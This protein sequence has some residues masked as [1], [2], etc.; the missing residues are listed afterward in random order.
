MD[1]ESYLGRPSSTKG[2]ISPNSAFCCFC[3]TEIETV[4]HLFFSCTESWKIWASWCCIWGISWVALANAWEFFC[5]WVDLVQDVAKNKIWKMAFFVITWS[6]WLFRNKMVFNGK[7][8][9]ELQLMDIIKTRIACW[10]KARWDNP[11]LSFLDL[12]RNLELGA[13][14]PK[15]K[16]DKKNLDWIKSLPDELKFNV[17]GAA[18]GCFGETGIGGVLRDY[19]GRIKLQFPKATG[20]GDSNLAELLAIKEAFL[21]FAASPWVNSYLLII[22][23]DSSNAVK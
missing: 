23:S 1:L 14:C 11:C 17:D 4:N 8:W 3:C 22:E 5:A 6:I 21:L 9:D 7:S 20:R 16:S 18:K 13:V 10:S 2:F 15:K 19:E 12:F